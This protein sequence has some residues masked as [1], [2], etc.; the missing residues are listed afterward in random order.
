MNERLTRLLDFLEDTLDAQRQAA[1]EAL[2]M[3]ALSYQSVERLPLVMVYPLPED[4]AFQPYSHHEIFADAEKMLFNELVYAF[5]TSI[6]CRNQVSD[7]LPLTVR[8]NYGAV[9]V[10]SLFGAHVEQ[11]GDNPPWIRHDANSG[12]DVRAILDRDPAD[13]SCGWSPKVLQTM[14]AYHEALDDR[15]ELKDLLHI[16]LSD[17]QG[18]MDNLELICGSKIFVELY[19]NPETVGRAL[20]RLAEAQIALVKHA[21]RWTTDLKDGFCHQH[22]V[23]LKGNILIR[24]D[25]STLIS[26]KM[27]R[28]LVAPHDARVLDAVGGGGIH[29]CGRIE[30][31]AAAF[32]EVPHVSSID[33]GQP[34]LNEVDNI[35]ARAS[36]FKIPLIRVNADEEE[37]LTGSIMERFPTGVVLMHQAGSLAEASRIMEAYK[38]A[39]T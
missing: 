12:I 11:R 6:A 19:A 22:A 33:F 38:E 28:D 35:Y 34:E 26:P 23:M 10:A 20:A 7:D 2:F 31:H 17:L 3:R 18:P 36:E 5:G 1:A 32:L 15:A 30:G 13:V 4:F 25:T 16:V 14:Q 9:I 27:Y 29:S 37:L 24:N 8:A 21:E 39:N